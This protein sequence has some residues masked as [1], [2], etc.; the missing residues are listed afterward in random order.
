MSERVLAIV[1]IIAQF[2]MIERDRLNTGELVEALISEGFD[3]E[4]IDAA[5]RW[6]ETVS[7]HPGPAS[8]PAS[9]RLPTQRI[10]TAEETRGI[11][12]EARGFLIR[13]RAMG[14]LDDE[15][16]ES[17]IERALQV[18]EDE[19]GLQEIKALTTLALFS[20]TSHDWRRE[21]DCFLTDDWARMV[22]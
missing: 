17:I 14:I 12:A 7:L 20:R 4:E 2:A 5:F 9:L 1:S 3:A 11:S 19:V 6:M 21:V 22:H 13:L 15:I 18:A 10:F 16:E 8:E